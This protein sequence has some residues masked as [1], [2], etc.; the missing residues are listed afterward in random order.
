MRLS[1]V[2]PVHNERENLRLLYASLTPVL[3]RIGHSYEI[4]F[5]DDGSDDGSAG[6]LE[7]LAL[8]DPAVKVVEFHHNFGQTAA[9]RAG[10]QAASGEIIVTM[11]G[12]L[13]NDP[14][15]IPMLLEKLDQGYDLVQGWRK[16]RKDSLLSRRLP[17]RIANWLIAKV[18]GVPVH[19]LGCMLKVIRR[20]TA[21]GL[22]LYG[23]RHRYI[24]ILAHQNGAQVAEIGT[25]HHARRFGKTKY[26]LGRTTRVLLDLAALQLFDRRTSGFLRSLGGIGV[27]LVA[28]AALSATALAGVGLLS[29]V[30]IGAELMVCGLAAILGIQGV[31]LGLLGEISARIGIQR[32]AAVSRI[33]GLVNLAES[34]SDR[35]RAA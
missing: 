32:E 15:D 21:A 1:L 34:R 27:L 31:L 6:V 26:G 25:R 17:S 10:I 13:Q 8:R 18:T 12:D 3:W 23:E 19:D 20:E 30:P 24:P 9:L 22:E 33:Q 7:D 11:D 14:A 5:I 16:N 28:L 35:V 4:I 29:G 2:I